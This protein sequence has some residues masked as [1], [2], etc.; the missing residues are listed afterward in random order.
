MRRLKNEQELNGEDRLVD[1]ERTGLNG[2]YRLAD[3][4]R[5][6]VEWRKQVG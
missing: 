2:E 6:R 5:A 1:K 3:K 4:E